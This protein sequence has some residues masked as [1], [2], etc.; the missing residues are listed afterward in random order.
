MKWL[1]TLLIVTQLCS[2]AVSMA[3][4]QKEEPAV[5]AVAQATQTP[6]STP[7]PTPEPTPT[8]TPE[9]TKKPTATPSQS[10]TPTQQKAKASETVAHTSRKEISYTEKD[11]EELARI[12]FW[13]AGSESEEGQMAVAEVILNRVQNNAWPDTIQGVIYQSSQFTP[14]E[15]P[16]YKTRPVDERF[17]TLA[18]RVL[19]GESVLCCDNVTYFSRGKSDYMADAFKIGHHW[20]GHYKN[21][22]Q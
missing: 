2:H 22:S 15:D 8:V 1:A 5:A 19:E 3:K 12:M 4:I 11:V 21:C 13:E 17:Y 9:P 10:A 20:F 14:T 7:E 6:V 18:R 16:D